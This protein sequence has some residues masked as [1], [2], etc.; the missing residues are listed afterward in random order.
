MV[1]IIFFIITLIILLYS[2]YL[3]FKAKN[4]KIQR[5]K[6]NQQLSEQINDKKRFSATLQQDII[7]Q[8]TQLNQTKQRIEDVNSQLSALNQ[9]VEQKKNNIQNYYNTL[10]KQSDQS[11][12]QYESLLDTCYSEKEEEYNFKINN[13]KL[14]KEQVEKDLDQ[15]KGVYEAATAARLREKEKED[16]ISFYKIQIS[17]KQISDINKLQL[18]K[19]DLY[20]PSIVAK[21]IWS[22]YIMKPAT[23]MCNRV[24]GSSSCCGIYKITNKITEEI[25]IGQSVNISDRFKQHIK[26]GLGIDAPATNKLYNNM[27][28][29]GVWNFTFEI[30][31]K[32]SRDKLNEKERFWIEMYQSNKI[33]LNV[34]KG[35][36]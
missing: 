34:T 9:Q 31:Q 32:C 25:Y 3:Y 20:D 17:D 30:L 5:I 33:G 1:N 11:F 7:K 18:W 26:C 21:I 27:Q 4:I 36:K 8:E 19:A 24:V 2:F 15:I 13:I 35:N 28:S 29:T 23:N 12:K 6:Q 10:K 16:K 14:R 22:S